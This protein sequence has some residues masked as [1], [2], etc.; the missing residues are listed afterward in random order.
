MEKPHLGALLLKGFVSP[1][2]FL[3]DQISDVSW[4]LICTLAMG[5]EHVWSKHGVTGVGFGNTRNDAWYWFSHF[6]RGQDNIDHS[7]MPLQYNTKCTA[8]RKRHWLLFAHT[9]KSKSKHF[10]K[11]RIFIPHPLYWT[12]SI[13]VFF[14][15]TGGRL[16][17]KDGLTRYGNSHVKDKTS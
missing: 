10:I 9:W 1:M 13:F 15:T 8:N 4:E 5:I 14:K 17:K 12:Y 6:K 7:C 3:S 16:N 11:N 2:S